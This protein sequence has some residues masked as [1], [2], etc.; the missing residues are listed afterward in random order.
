MTIDITNGQDIIDIVSDGFVTCLKIREPIAI[1]WYDCAGSAG[2][3]FAFTSNFE[4]IAKSFNEVLVNG[5][6]SQVLNSIAE[7]LQ[8]FA[9]G[10]YKV[11][12][13]RYKRYYY[14]L[15]Y[16]YQQIDNSFFY[17]YH[18]YNPGG[19]NAMFTQTFSKINENTLAYYEKIILDGVRPKAVLFQAIFQEEENSN[20]NSF[21]SPMYILDGHHKLLAYKNLKI[22]PELILISKEILGE[23][24]FKE[25]E[26]TLYFKYEYFLT[27]KHKQ[28]I[29][30]HTPKILVDNSTESYNYNSHFDNYLKTTYRIEVVV[31]KL[32]KKLFESNDMTNII[33]LIKKLKVIEGRNFEQ[34]IMLLYYYTTT[35]I[36]SNCNWDMLAIKTT[37][38]FVNWT[39]KMFGRTIREIENNIS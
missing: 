14:D 19:D 37:E 6:D 20:W 16:E 35:S 8:L 1:D 23:K 38:D 9:S 30:S 12:V 34:N 17:N 31:L 7:F 32:F 15:H 4:P 2:K 21:D 39:I 18:Y 3:Y 13:D 10:K 33:W 28:H 11:S 29:I 26:N 24:V 27:E 22:D 25:N 36:D 5:N